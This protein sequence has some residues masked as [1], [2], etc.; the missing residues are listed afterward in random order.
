MT[1]SASVVVVS[2][3]RPEP[4][5]RCLM[6]LEQQ[7]HPSFEVVVVADPAGLAAAGARWPGKVKLVGCDVANIAVA[8]NLGIGAAAGEIVAFID[9][10]AVAETGWLTALTAAF[11]LPSLVAAGGY[12]RGRN[13]ISFQWRGR[14]V[15]RDGRSFDL[16]VAGT[17]PVVPCPTPGRVVR[18]EGTNMAF[19]RR[20]L[21][22]LG[23]F[24]AEFAFYHDETDLILRLADRGLATAIVPLAEVHHGFAASDRRRVDR[25]P[26]GL[27]QIGASSALFLR[28]HGQAANVAARQAEL[29]DEQRGRLLAHMLAGRCEPRIVARL[30]A[31]FDSGFMQGLG[32]CLAAPA[33]IGPPPGFL[34][35]AAPPAGSVFLSGRPSDRKCLTA[36]AR[37]LR[38]AGLVVTIVVLSPTALF[39][40]VSFGGDGIWLQQGGLYGRAERD[41]PLIRRWTFRDRLARERARVAEQ[42]QFSDCHSAVA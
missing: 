1:D 25:M 42:R 3:G 33:N 12:V 36:E 41:E 35:F 38:A 4:L 9:D 16:G 32:N 19:R 29:H 20:A 27:R 7:V 11:A 31:E 24:D 14:E 23:G 5:V 30:L 13:G 8:R 39:H 28:K 17:R 26:T 2:R 22:E 6:S 18:V 37:R 15:D 10:D 40:Q 34:P 21:V